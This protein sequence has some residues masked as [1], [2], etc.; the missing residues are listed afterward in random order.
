MVNAETDAEQKQVLVIGHRGMLGQDLLP[1]LQARPGYQVTGWDLPEVDIT[2]LAQVSACLHQLK[3]DVV[4]NTAAYTNVEACETQPA[5]AY[6]VNAV[7]AGHVAQA[8]GQLGARLI[9]ISTDYVFDGQAV[10]PYVES[11]CAGSLNVYGWSKLAGE[12]VVQ[13]AHPQAV[14]VRTAWLF[15]RHGKNFVETMLKLGQTRNQIN[16]VDDQC[17]SP[18]STQELCRAILALVEHDGCGI[19]HAAG[20]GSCTWFE[21]AQS[22]FAY[23]GM[24]HIQVSPIKTKDYP[25][26][27][28]RPPFSALD[29]SKLSR[30]VGI[31]MQPWQ[32]SLLSYLNAIP[33]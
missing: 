5:T 31:R 28:A 23:T 17:G 27:A 33:A 21:L 15:G 30:E 3:P 18:T 12:L 16:V 24:D 9:H 19:Y 2:N 8:C 10:S 4:V 20:A 25:L 26:R 6:Q 22:I 29:S 14:I 7:G 1:L 11:A 13:T 32:E